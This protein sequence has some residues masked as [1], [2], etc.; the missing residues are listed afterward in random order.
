MLIDVDGLCDDWKQVMSQLRQQLPGLSVIVG[1]GET[2]KSASIALDAG[3]DEFVSRP[4]IAAEL[5]ARVH[6]ALRRADGPH[7]QSM[8]LTCGCCRLDVAGRKLVTASR[9]VEL[10]GRE[11]AL[12]RMMFQSVGGVVSRRALARIW[13]ME[14]DLA[15]RSI[16]QHIYQL[17]RKI[18]LCAGADVTLRNV[19]ARGYQLESMAAASGNMKSSVPG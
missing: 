13:E 1:T 12:A 9:S 16:E 6:A 14:E 5:S 3:A 11:T 8:T 15:S 7:R 4:W 19:Y 17:R 10:T 2:P 18:R